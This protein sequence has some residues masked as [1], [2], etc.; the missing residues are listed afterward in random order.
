MDART[1]FPLLARSGCWASLALGLPGP[2]LSA[3]DRDAWI[4]PA[5]PSAGPRLSQSRGDQ[6]VLVISVE[7]VDRLVEPGTWPPTATKARQIAE[8]LNQDFMA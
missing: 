5:T 4:F 2:A 3:L 6:K 1:S 7:T 8:G